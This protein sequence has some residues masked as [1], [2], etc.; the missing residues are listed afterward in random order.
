MAIII[1]SFEKCS[2]LNEWIGGL[3]VI[4]KTVYPSQILRVWAS[5][6]H[7]HLWRLRNTDT[8][9]YYYY[10]HKCVPHSHPPNDSALTPSCAYFSAPAPP[11][12]PRNL[13]TPAPGTTAH[14]HFPEQATSFLIRAGQSKTIQRRGSGPLGWQ[15]DWQ[16]CKRAIQP[17][18]PPGRQ[19]GITGCHCEASG[20]LVHR[21][22]EQSP[23]RN[24]QQAKEQ[25]SRLAYAMLNA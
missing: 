25:K 17:H 13:V 24:C 12:A 18:C 6:V 15:P 10:P 21:A 22:A 1:R 8:T 4:V 19:A 14:L 7:V 2:P 9:R 16:S 11:D 20:E 3:P 5:Y 23:W